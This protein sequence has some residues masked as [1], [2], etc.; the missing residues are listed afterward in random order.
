MHTDIRTRNTVE[1][2]VYKKTNKTHLMGG[3]GRN[4]VKRVFI[5][6]TYLFTTNSKTPK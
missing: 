3:G 1:R 6:Y 2:L 5:R 4:F